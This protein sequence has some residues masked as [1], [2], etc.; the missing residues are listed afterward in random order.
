MFGATCAVEEF[1][2][3]AVT[4][5]DATVHP[6]NCREVIL[7]FQS[8][9][10]KPTHTY[11]LTMQ[12]LFSLPF[13]YHVMV[14]LHT[15]PQPVGRLM[16]ASSYFYQWS[17]DSILPG[18]VWP[19]DNLA[20]IELLPAMLEEP[21]PLDP[22]KNKTLNSTLKNYHL[23]IETLQMPTANNYFTQG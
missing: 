7:I 10:L 15:F 18:P 23:N 21:P 6:C 3:I 4:A 9:L 8:C 22:E 2:Q 5:F 16:T 17:K 13:R 1:R 19:Q 12:T 14:A 11:T 20:H